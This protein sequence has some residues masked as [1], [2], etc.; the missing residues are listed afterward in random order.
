MSFSD[1]LSVEA[2]PVR[3]DKEGKP[4]VEISHYSEIDNAIWMDERKDDAEYVTTLRHE[5]GHFVDA[6]MKRPSVLQEFESA[7]QA[8]KELLNKSNIDNLLDEVGVGSVIYSRYISDILSALTFNDSKIIDFYY[9]DGLPFYGH[10]IL[11]WNGVQGPDNAVQKEIFANLFAIFA[12]NNDNVV[13]FADKW[14]PNMVCQFNNIV[15]KNSYG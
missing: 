2:V 15:R 4:H 1:K 3:F 12:E 11:Y 5:M 7:I 9:S 6:Q 10:D 14:F 13:T 8:D